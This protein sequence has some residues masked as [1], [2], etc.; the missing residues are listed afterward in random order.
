MRRYEKI[1]NEG[2]DRKGKPYQVKVLH[3]GLKKIHIGEDVWV[4][5]RQN[6]VPGKGLHMVIYGPDRKEYH[7]YGNDVTN[8]TKS[9]DSDHYDEWGYGNRNGNRAIE[10]KVKIHVLTSILDEKENWCFDLTKIP[11]VGPLKVIYSNGTI[12]NI[13]FGGEFSE[14][15][16][17]R[18]WG[19]KYN[20]KPVG[21]RYGISKKLI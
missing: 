11:A 5:G 8:L 4:Y 18:K 2:I 16:L 13:D 21:Y 7:V 15:E 9:G 14:A 1:V 20:V 3:R 12:K 19:Y 6:N 10:S 17:T